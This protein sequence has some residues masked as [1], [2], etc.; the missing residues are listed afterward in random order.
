MAQLIYDLKCANPGA[1]ISV[2]LVS[3]VGVGVIAAGVAK[4]KSEHILVCKQTHFCKQ[5]FFKQKFF[6]QIL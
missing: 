4:G 5:K 1:R 6:K 2:K 3:E